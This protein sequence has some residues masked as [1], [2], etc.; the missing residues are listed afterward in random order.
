MHEEEKLPSFKQSGNIN[1][2]GLQIESRHKFM[3]LIEKLPGLCV[4]LMSRSFRIFKIST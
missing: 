2:G 4:L 3:I 1:L